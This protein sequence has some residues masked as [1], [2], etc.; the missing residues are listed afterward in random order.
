MRVIGAILAL[1]LAIA[2]TPSAGAAAQ[3]DDPL[4]PLPD[5]A[6]ATSAARVV[7]AV[8][9]YC[10]RSVK[11]EGSMTSTGFDSVV[12]FDLDSRTFSWG[13]RISAQGDGF[14]GQPFDPLFENGPPPANM[15]LS[16]RYSY[17]S[18][19]TRRP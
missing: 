10:P 2:A 5:E 1:A 19:S 9:R 11:N 3:A 14:V 8:C 6:N 12:G 4:A 16:K 7:M 18:L 13:M 17:I 15:P